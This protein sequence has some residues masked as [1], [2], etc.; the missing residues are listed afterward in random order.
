MKLVTQPGG[1]SPINAGT[2]ATVFTEM[3]LASQVKGAR[4]LGA[5]Q[6]KRNVYH[7]LVD[8]PS[9]NLHKDEGEELEQSL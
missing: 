8:H 7:V 4:V 6:R 3:E 1:P 9:R 5:S 2:A